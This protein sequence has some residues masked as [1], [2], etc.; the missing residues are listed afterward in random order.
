MTVASLGIGAGSARVFVL[1]E[2]RAP[3]PIMPLRLFARRE[4]DGAYAA[5]LLVIPGWSASGSSRLSSSRR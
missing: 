5:R 4:R 2:R 1:V 3:Q